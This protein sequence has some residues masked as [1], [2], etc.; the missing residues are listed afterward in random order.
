MQ[1]FAPGSGLLGEVQLRRAATSKASRPGLRTA[2]LSGSSQGANDPNLSDLEKEKAKGLADAWIKVDK[3]NECKV[4]LKGRS[5]FLLGLPSE[6]LRAVGLLIQ[7]RFENYRFL[8]AVEIVAG[9]V[10]QSATCEDPR[11]LDEALGL[12]AVLDVEEQVMDQLQGKPPPLLL[13]GHRRRRRP[14]GPRNSKN[15]TSQTNL[16]RWGPARTTMRAGRHLQKIVVLGPFW[17]S[18]RVCPARGG[19]MGLWA[20]LRCTFAATCGR[21]RRLGAGEEFLPS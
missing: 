13:H 11:P 19:G 10:K 2:V 15:R 4:A 14:S 9:A 12:E 21:T 5:I 8:D 17:R 3:V 18:R 20:L 16:R 7:K 1:A 6:P